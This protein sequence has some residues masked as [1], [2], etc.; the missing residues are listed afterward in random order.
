MASL[1]ERLASSARESHEAALAEGRTRGARAQRVLAELEETKVTQSA[2]LATATTVAQRAHADASAAAKAV[3]E[4]A[5]VAAVAEGEMLH[6]VVLGEQARRERTALAGQQE[7]RQAAARVSLLASRRQRGALRAAREAAAEAEAARA[8]A[9]AACQRVAAATSGGWLVD[10]TLAQLRQQTEHRLRLECLA[11]ED[12]SAVA[13]EARSRMEQA[14]A[15]ARERADVI[16]AEAARLVAATEARQ[17]AEAR[18]AQAQ[19]AAEMIETKLRADQTTAKGFGLG[20]AAGIGGHALETA[21]AQAE[22]AAAA[23][24]ERERRAV[25]RLRLIDPEYHPAAADD[26]D[27]SATAAP[28]AAPSLASVLR[29]ASEDMRLPRCLL[30]LEVIAGRHLGVR[31]T[32]TAEAAVPLLEA[33]RRRNEGVRVWPITSLRAR[34]VPPASV[35][36]LQRR[37]GDQHVIAPAA[38]IASAGPVQGRV[39][40][41]TAAASAAAAATGT[42]GG[43]RR[44]TAGTGGGPD[45]HR[46]GDGECG[47]V[48]DDS[49]DREPLEAGTAAN[50]ASGRG[51]LW[52]A[53]EHAFGSS[54]IISNDEIAEA[55]LEAPGVVR[56]VTLAGTVHERAKLQGGYRDGAG[57]LNGFVALF[58]YQGAAAAAA[59]ATEHAESL[60]RA[61]ATHRAAPRA[62]A[63]AAA[64][65]A[66][67]ERLA[68][69]LA[70]LR[71]SHAHE[72]AA[73]G[74]AAAM[75]G[76][77]SGRATAAASHAERLQADVAALNAIGSGGGEGVNGRSATIAA[78]RQLR[79]RREEHAAAARALMERL[80]AEARRS[81]SA[82][83]DGVAMDEEGDEEGLSLIHI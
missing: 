67:V 2:R 72:H 59:A 76:E 6:A 55:C 49:T 7:R 23:A 58:E 1:A 4:A 21:A 12:A 75:L 19:A 39:R 70:Q 61:L 26:D 77:Q 28:T 24:H 51:T 46:G 57:Q 62:A 17:V 56:C 66:G 11:H 64:A 78:L 9:H 68:A 69:R 83:G 74:E 8:E 43:E 44:G 25:A 14:E 20:G 3:E 36:A 15:E 42:G 50:G 30:A 54:L 41:W 5:E 38:L 71:A 33:A 60:A 73:V 48:N 27:T 79:A 53:V 40:Q 22:A 18:A 32:G 16:V 47:G 82:E 80:E 37:F 34:A 31:L 13:A 10:G 63:A 65:T 45:G 35:A 81:E 52:A 29:L